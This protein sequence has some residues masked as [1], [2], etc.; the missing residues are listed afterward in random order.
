MAGE[1]HSGSQAHEGFEGLSGSSVKLH[2]RVQIAHFDQVE[3]KF[4]YWIAGSD[5]KFIVG[6]Q[7]MTSSGIFDTELVGLIYGEYYNF[8]AYAIDP[9]WLTEWRIGTTIQFRCGY[10]DEEVDEGAYGVYGRIWNWFRY[11][12]AGHWSILLIGMGLVALIFHRRREI[13]II[14]CLFI[15]GAGIVVGW[16]DTWVIVL[17]SLGAG[18]TI[19]RWLTGRRTSPL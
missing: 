13:A 2:G 4:F 16:V 1:A 17:L 7:T 15:L 5:E 11:S 18:F 9:V 10:W 12:T 14:M 8:Q 6:T 19:W 3:V